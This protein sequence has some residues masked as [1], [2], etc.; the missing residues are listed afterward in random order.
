MTMRNLVLVG[1]LVSLLAG[2][3]SFS[4]L[5][6]SGS[7]LACKAPDGVTCTSVSGIYANSL[8]EGLPGQ[9]PKGE[10]AGSKK[11]EPGASDKVAPPSPYFS[12]R[13]LATPNSGDPI[14]MAPL[15]LRVWIAPW[16]DTDGDL[17]DQHYL[18]TVVHNGR[19]LIESNR[20]AIQN[21]YKPVFPL[22]GKTPVDPDDAKP[23]AASA[24]HGMPGARGETDK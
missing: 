9:Q 19:W 22:K 20:Q 13:D 23:A 15:V 21:A 11:K 5:S 2:C 3:S 24:L 10:S 4:G 17:H 14:R 18:Y 16:E 1:G 8:D 6:G 12:P 7:N